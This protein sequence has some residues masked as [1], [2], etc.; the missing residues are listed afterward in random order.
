MSDFDEL[1]NRLRAISEELAEVSARLQ[2]TAEAAQGRDF[3]AADPDGRAE[4]VVDG[5]PRVVELNL[6]PD[7]LRSGPEE[8]D[9]LLTGLLNDGLTQARAA[10]RQAMLEALPEQIRDEVAR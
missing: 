10:T 3:R 1:G 2:S 9:R 7:A 5:R 6:R 8:L 4:V